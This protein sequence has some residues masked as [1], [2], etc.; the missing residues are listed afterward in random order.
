MS[1]FDELV[2]QD[3]QKREASINSRVRDYQKNK[4]V[5]GEILEDNETNFAGVV[6]EVIAKFYRDAEGKDIFTRRVMN[7][8]AMLLITTHVNSILCD[9]A[10]ADEQEENPLEDKGERI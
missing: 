3:A 10:E 7:R 9:M 6:A 4:I 8:D 1:R 5:I 2:E